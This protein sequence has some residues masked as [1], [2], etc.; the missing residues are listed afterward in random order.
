[1]SDHYPCP[2]CLR[3]AY[4]WECS[5]CGWPHYEQQAERR[6]IEAKIRQLEHQAEERHWNNDPVVKAQTLEEALHELT[7]LQLKEDIEPNKLR[8]YLLVIHQH[9]MNQPRQ[10]HW[11]KRLVGAQ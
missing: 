2:K 6:R 4:G 8:K 1:M 11:L 10:T 7:E 5:S 9:Q 3:D